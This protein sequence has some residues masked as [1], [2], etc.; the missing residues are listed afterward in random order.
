MMLGQLEVEAGH[1]LL[2]IGAGTGYNAALLAQLVGDHGR[3]TTIN[4][5]DDIVSGSS[6]S[7]RASRSA[8]GPRTG[9]SPRASSPTTTT[10]RPL[11]TRQRSLPH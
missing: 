4:V 2:E 3:V 5:D 10:A 11:K 8:H 6:G 9:N 7:S 1:R